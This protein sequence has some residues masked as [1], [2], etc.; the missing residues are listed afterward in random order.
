ML[1][2]INIRFGSI[3]QSKKKASTI[4]LIITVSGF[5]L[6]KCYKQNNQ[7]Y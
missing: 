3:H 2:K 5:D 6:L 1:I 7:H 4:L